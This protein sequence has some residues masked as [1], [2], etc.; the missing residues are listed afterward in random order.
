MPINHDPP[1]RRDL[2]MHI[3]QHRSFEWWENTNN[4][5]YR[6]DHDED[7]NNMPYEDEQNT[8]NSHLMRID[9]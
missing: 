1:L 9:F 6:P 8:H 3:Q 7:I 5:S 4:T 2:S